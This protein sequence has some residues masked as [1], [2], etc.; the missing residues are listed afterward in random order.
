MGG[1]V[2]GGGCEEWCEMVIGGQN[3]SPSAYECGYVRA[4]QL[5]SGMGVRSP[6]MAGRRSAAAG[7]PCSKQWALATCV[8]LCSVS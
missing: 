7:P 8:Q 4:R 5:G 2:C 1:D 6:Q 3:G